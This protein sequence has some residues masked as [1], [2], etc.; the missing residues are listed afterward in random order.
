MHPIVRKPWFTDSWSTLDPLQCIMG[1]DPPQN[2]CARLIK[3]KIYKTYTKLQ[4]LGDHVPIATLHNLTTKLTF[5]LN[6]HSL[7]STTFICRVI[8]TNF[9]LG[10]L[11]V[12]ALAHEGCLTCILNPCGKWTRVVGPLPS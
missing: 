5:H 8:A 12:I 6:S 11:I 10:L 2:P 9:I 3:T 1:F 4:L 7:D